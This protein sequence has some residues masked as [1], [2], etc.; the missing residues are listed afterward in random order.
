LQ[1]W[2]RNG[3]ARAKPDLVKPASGPDLDA[4]GGVRAG[5]VVEALPI[6]LVLV[7]R[8]SRKV[9]Y[10][11]PAAVTL[12]GLGAV[13]GERF[14]LSL[15]TGKH[16]LPASEV[17][18]AGLQVEI[19]R[20]D[21]TF[22][23]VV[24]Q[25][26][27]ETAWTSQDTER[28]AFEDTLTGL[29]NLN[30]L[31]QFIEFTCTQ[32]HR[33]ER[34]ASLLLL[35]IDQ[36]H[37]IHRELGQSVGDELLC[38]MATRLQQAVRSSDIVGRHS[39]DKFIIILTELTSDRSKDRE[40]ARE[41]PVP[42]RAARVAERLVA[43]FS[44]PFE[45][46]S[47]P[48]H[49]QVSIG[50]S[51]CPGDAHTPQDFLEH[52]EIALAQARLREEGRS[53]LL[54]EPA[55]SAELVQQRQQAEQL[56]QLLNEDKLEAWLEPVFAGVTLTAVMLRP[57][58]PG[59]TV[60][61]KLVEAAESIGLGPRVFDWLLRR[62][63]ELAGTLNPGVRLILALQPRQLLNADLGTVL[64]SFQEQTGLDATRIVL[65]ISEVAIATDLRK[66]L[67]AVKRLQDLG[68]GLLL[69]CGPRGLH[70]LPILQQLKPD[71]LE[72]PRD[73]VVGLPHNAQ[74]AAMAK[75]CS[76]AAA[77]FGVA[78]IAPG[79]ENEEQHIWLQEN[80]FALSAGPY[81]KV[82]S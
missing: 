16:V 68:F 17:E 44:K 59:T 53:F 71:Y 78:A 25:E 39:Q 79:I 46:Q 42:E 45:A 47:N 77:Q 7:D 30:I 62:N 2:L 63:T 51:L 41:I 4:L 64:S 81:W 8:A 18:L 60:P 19:V 76:Q 6:G 26:H 9:L 67:G 14:P 15:G 65:K 80:G 31:R 61:G 70:S 56:D 20:N 50:V 40:N 82:R 37:T 58:L 21:P 11:N 22:D 72:I 74:C 28:L 43:E 29:P 55:F 49:L 13:A 48:L 27:E 5:T 34:S 24:L 35:G 1:T 32:T 12:L 33:Y 73:L 57:C 54:Y 38:Q 36:F 3:A 23:L 52:A 66:R 75:A 69:E 10:S